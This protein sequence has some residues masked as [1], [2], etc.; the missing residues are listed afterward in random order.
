[1]RRFQSR[2]IQQKL[3]MIIMGVSS[4]VL[5]LSMAAIAV[6]QIIIS[7]R[8]LVA[9]A[10]LIAH[11][12]GAN[13]TAALAFNDAKAATETLAALRMDRSTKLAAIFNKN[14]AVFATYEAAKAQ[15]PR[16]QKSPATNALVS[17]GTDG[18]PMLE[19]GHTFYADHL[20]LYTPIVLDGER[21]GTVYVQRDLS[22]L[23]ELL[24]R[25]IVFGAGIIIALALLAYVLSLKLRHVIAGPDTESS[26]AP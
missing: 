15:R 23:N 7:K 2:S 20:D 10:S 3:T 12:I 13:T 21:I 22:E 19:D 24:R 14:G 16:G 4:L 11:V 18:R 9:E 5:V 17:G 25:W 8:A 6:N 26:R 1:M